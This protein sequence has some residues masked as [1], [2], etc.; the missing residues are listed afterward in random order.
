ML[1]YSHLATDSRVLRQVRSL[2]ERYAVTSATFG[3]S[4]I[5][6]V[7]HVE[8]TDPPPYRNAWI[9]RWLYAALYI[10]RFFPILQRFNPRDRAALAALSGRSW[11]VIVANDVNTIPLAARL[12]ARCGVLADLHEYASRQEEHSTSWRLLHA[13]YAR[14]LVRRVAS[15]ASAVTTVSQGIADEYRRE[16]GIEAEVVTNASDYRELVPAPMGSTIR[17]VHSG[18]PAVQRRLEIMIDAMKLTKADVTLDFYLIEDGSAYLTELK[19]RAS[20]IDTVRFNTPV[21]P[22]KLVEALNQYDVGLSIFA[23]TTFNLAWCLPNKFFD[24]VQARIGVIVGPSPEMQRIVEERGIGVVMKDFTAESLAEV[25]NSVRPEV[26]RSWKQASDRN[27]HIL[28]SETQNL[29]WHGA[30]DKLIASAG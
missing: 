23:P 15:G 20:G 21:K 17:L 13:P 26:V 9:G 27:A 29:V 1:C 14:W 4:P 12:G 18:V 7:E 5:E 28:S 30:V 25:L 19:E 10:L 6:G 3:A 11:D 8:L 22:G 24:Y 2:S 16:Y